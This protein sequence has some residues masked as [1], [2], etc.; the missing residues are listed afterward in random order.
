MNM[1]NFFRKDGI[2]EILKSVKENPNISYDKLLI[3]LQVNEPFFKEN[4][5]KEAIRLLIL[6]GQISLDDKGMVNICHT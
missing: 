5:A 4:T 6:D 1:G 2:A 3:K